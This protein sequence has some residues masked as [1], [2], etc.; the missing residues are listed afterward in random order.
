MFCTQITENIELEQSC[1]ICFEN[2]D[3]YNVG[4]VQ[5]QNLV[6]NIYCG[7]N[8]WIHETCFLQWLVTRPYS[9]DLKC[10]VCSSAVERKRTFYEST[11][12]ACRLSRARQNQLC[13]YI[14]CLSTIGILLLF[15]YGG[16]N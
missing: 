15:L 3:E 4:V 14:L 1:I 11:R 12:D 9:S 5:S 7:C 16:K 13:H 10:L 6:K 2:S 8:Y